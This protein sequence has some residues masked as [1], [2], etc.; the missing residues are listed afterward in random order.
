MLDW[1]LLI[2]CIAETLFVS[3]QMIIAQEMCQFYQ[4]LTVH[5]YSVLDG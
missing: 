3:S 1:R 4:A 5:L 2:D